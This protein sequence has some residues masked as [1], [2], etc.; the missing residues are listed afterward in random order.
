[1]PRSA[2]AVTL[3]PF[4]FSC[5]RSGDSLAQVTPLAERMLCSSTDRLQVP[6]GYRVMVGQE[7]R[8]PPSPEEG[9]VGVVWGGVVSG[10]WVLVFWAGSGRRGSARR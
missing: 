6:P 7:K 3:E 2:R 10:F 5:S 9:W 4:P 8:M 1:M